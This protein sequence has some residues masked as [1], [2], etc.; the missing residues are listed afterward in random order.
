[1]RGILHWMLSRIGG[2]SVPYLCL[3]G[4]RMKRD[5]GYCWLKGSNYSEEKMVSHFVSGI[6]PWI[7]LLKTLCAVLLFSSQ[8]YYWYS[9]KNNII[10]TT[11]ILLTNNPFLSALVHILHESQACNM[12]NT[13]NYSLF[14]W[15]LERGIK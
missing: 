12:K 4:G 13:N 11:I 1:M 5:W 15:Y 3:L 8:N 6:W 10:S 14:K 2:N 9:F 7:F